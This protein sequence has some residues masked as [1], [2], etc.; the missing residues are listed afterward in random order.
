MMMVMNFAVGM[1]TYLAA[2]HY[3]SPF[4]IQLRM[5]FADLKSKH[6]TGEVERL[7]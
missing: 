7:S 5:G 4:V 2:H 1:E 6:I 3:Q